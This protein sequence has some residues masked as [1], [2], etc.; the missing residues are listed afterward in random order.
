MSEPIDLEFHRLMKLGGVKLAAF[1]EPLRKNLAH[2]QSIDV[3]KLDGRELRKIRDRILH[4]KWMLLACDPEIRTRIVEKMGDR[5]SS[6]TFEEI[7]ASAPEPPTVN[8]S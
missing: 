4:T 6:A 2:L 1:V 5:A 7:L 8:F 3:S